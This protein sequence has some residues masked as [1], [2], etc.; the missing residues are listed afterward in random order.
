M[1]RFGFIEWIANSIAFLALAGSLAHTIFVSLYIAIPFY[2]TIAITF[3]FYLVLS[4]LFMWP[5][6]ILLGITSVPIAIW[7]LKIPLPDNWFISVIEFL[8]WFS[9]LSFR[10]DSF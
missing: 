10:I 8:Q 3:L 5:I 2:K 9:L 6:V 7:L 4:I 1:K